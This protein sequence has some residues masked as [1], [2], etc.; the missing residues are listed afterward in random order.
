M[1]RLLSKEDELQVARNDL[2]SK[3]DE[4]QVAWNDLQ[5]KNSELHSVRQELEEA[6]LQHRQGAQMFRE[7]GAVPSRLPRIV[8]HA[9]A[10][11]Q[12]QNEQLATSLAAV[13]SLVRPGRSSWLG[14]SMSPPW[15][16]SARRFLRPWN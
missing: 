15:S 4:L 3:E 6:T 7:P 1:E 2:Q 10:E 11:M 14:K 9:L 13:C 8:S 16:F 12:R 5:S